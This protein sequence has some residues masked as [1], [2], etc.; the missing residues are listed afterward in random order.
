MKIKVLTKEDT[1]ILKGFAILCILMHNYFH[2]LE[3][4]ANM[5]NEF[6]FNAENVLKFLS[7]FAEYPM[8]SINILFSYLGHYGVQLFIFISGYGLAASMMNSYNGY[9]SFI[10]GRLRK[11]CPLVFIAISS[12]YLMTVLV[13]HHIIDIIGVKSLFYKLL[14]IHTLIPNE[15]MSYIGPLWFVGMIFQLYLLFPI[16]YKAVMKWGIKA[17]CVICSLSYICIYLCLYYPILPAGINMMQNF[18]GHLPEFTMGILFFKMKDRTISILY[19]ITALMFFCLGNVY[20]MFFPLT[21]I[22]ITYMMVCIYWLPKSN[23]ELMDIVRRFFVFFGKISM[24]LFATHSILRVPFVEI[25]QRAN[26]PMYTLYVL[27]LYLICAILVSLGAKIVYEKMV[28][29]K[30]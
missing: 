8:E 22:C 23:N 28:N 15:G 6:G 14:M 30:Q 21:F 24:V 27:V 3:P 20:K 1:S 4:I 17:F 9:K 12:H 29:Y 5:E 13:S 7:A 26:N 25:A 16:L 19:F 2:W 10:Y 18:V 11:L